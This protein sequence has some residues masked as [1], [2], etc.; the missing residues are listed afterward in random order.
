MITGGIQ[1][2]SRE[3]LYYELGLHLLVKRCW[4]N[5]LAFFVKL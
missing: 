5:K 2:T 3:Q 4:H 1:G